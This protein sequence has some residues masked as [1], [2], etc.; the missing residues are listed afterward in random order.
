MKEAQ[1]KNGNGIKEKNISLCVKKEDS[2]SE[3]DDKLESSLK[4]AEAG[5]ESNV[6]IEEL[7]HPSSDLE[8]E[9][10]FDEE[11]QP[12]EGTYKPYVAL[13]VVTVLYSWERQL[14]LTLPLSTQEHIK[15][16]PGNW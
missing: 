14:N 10:L 5:G 4:A 6:I 8:P 13:A 15:W 11:L 1:I 9:E 12:T 3:K 16:L 7:G 2:T